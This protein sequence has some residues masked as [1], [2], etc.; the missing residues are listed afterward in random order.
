MG[1]CEVFI[2]ELEGKRFHIIKNQKDSKQIIRRKHYR[3][4]IGGESRIIS[5]VT[6]EKIEAL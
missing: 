3:V 4:F 2:E 1:K 5:L 6:N